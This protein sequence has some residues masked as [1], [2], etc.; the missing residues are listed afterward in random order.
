ML[1]SLIFYCT[2][3]GLATMSNS[4]SILLIQPVSSTSHHVW[5]ISLLKGLLHNGH[6]VHIVSIHEPNI[7][8][9]LAQNMTYAVFGDIMKELAESKDYDPNE[10]ERLSIIE[11]IY[12]VY[13][14]GISF[15][16][17]TIAI[18]EAR[19]LLEMI[20]NVE[21][22]V[23]VIDVTLYQCLYGLWEVA[24]GKPPI[25]GLI[26]YGPAPW[27]KHY[28]GGTNYP[29]VRSYVSTTYARG[30]N[31]WQKTWN[32]L[33][34]IVDDLLR[35]YYYMPICQQIAEQYIGHEIR[36]LH[37]LEKNISIL[38][39]NTHST[40]EPG[41]PL[42]PNAIEIGGLN[43]QIDEIRTADEEIETY[44][45]NI[46]E[47]LDGADNGAIVISLGTNVNW[48][49]IGLDKLKAVTQA[50]S[51]LK[52]RILWKLDVE[53]LSQLPSNIMIVKWIPQN[54]ILTHKNVKAIWTHAGLLS[55]H[56]AVWHGVPIIGM[57]FFL[58]QRY[59][60]ALLLQKGVAVRLDVK[61]L[62]TESVS[63][64]FEKILYNESYTKN[65]KQ[66]SNEFRDRP[67]PPLDLAVWWIEYAAR[68]PR[69]SLGSPLRFQSWM[70]QNLID[71][72]AFL[73]FNLI[74][75]LTVVFFV[76]KKLFSFCRNRVCPASKLQKSKQ[77]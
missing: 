70:E 51:K 5:T 14:W 15:C 31:L 1:K 76:F 77:M 65:M 42:P 75:I 73:I 62:S 26:P 23:I 72:Y 11:G 69:G 49:S 9:K 67:V 4:L 44:P 66:L 41:I 55:T 60:M 19:E 61:T 21:F 25:V 27:L 2:L 22:D 34:Y 53:L 7:K 8:G 54:K 18:K 36:P 38:L 35:Q 37:E 33:Y 10:W 28:I 24:K 45:D 71:V 47:F 30:E 12:F 68:H 29:T 3:M 56:E 13:N 43:A 16:E 32:T 46:R 48:K 39:I 20:K 58:D 64:A 17:K 6:H 74:I 57:P 59:N 40:F 52:Q 63:D 50:L